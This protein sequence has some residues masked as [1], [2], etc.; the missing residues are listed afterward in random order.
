MCCA[1]S[2]T[3]PIL[4]P[5]PI[6]RDVNG[7]VGAPTIRLCDVAAPLRIV[8]GG[9]ESLDDSVE[10]ACAPSRLRTGVVPEFLLWA[11]I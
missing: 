4:D 11:M 10:G 9:L 2:D 3:L 5:S 7:D 6:F 8:E 1:T